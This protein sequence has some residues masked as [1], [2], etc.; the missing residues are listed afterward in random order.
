MH[1]A[2]DPLYTQ[3]RIGISTRPNVHGRRLVASPALVINNV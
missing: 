3:E 2:L 1:D